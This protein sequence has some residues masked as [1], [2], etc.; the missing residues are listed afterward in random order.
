MP[1]EESPSIASTSLVRASGSATA[2]LL[3]SHT[4]SA[5]LL[6][7]YLI[8]TLLPPAKPRFEP[9]WMISTSC[10]CRRRCPSEP[11]VESLSTTTIREFGQVSPRQDS[12]HSR[13]SRHPFQLRITMHTKG[14]RSLSFMVLFFNAIRELSNNFPQPFIK[15]FLSP[16][17]RPFLSSFSEPGV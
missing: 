5:P 15:H 13:V 11:S 1:A 6:I 8:P 12:T 9:L 10:S 4:K 3:R 17:S 14:N 16:C 2:S 7:A